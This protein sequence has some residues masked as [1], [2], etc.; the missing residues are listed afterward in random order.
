MLRWMCRSAMSFLRLSN[1]PSPRMVWIRN[2][3]RRYT[4]LICLIDMNS[5]VSFILPIHSAVPKLTPCEMLIKK[6]ILLINIRSMARTILRCQ[7]IMAGGI[8]PCRTWTA[9]GVDQGVLPL[10]EARLG[11]KI[12]SAA[13]TASTVTGQFGSKFCSM[14][15]IR[16]AVDGCP[17]DI[18]I[19]LAC[20]AF[21]ISR[22]VYC[23]FMSATVVTSAVS[24]CRGLVSR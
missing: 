8:V 18:C 1:C 15:L 20:C 19:F 13:F 7:S 12:D 23:A 17:M 5:V 21:Q 24:S 2:P 11:P 10:I 22:G 4:L 16:V 9:V 3:R 6:G 14:I